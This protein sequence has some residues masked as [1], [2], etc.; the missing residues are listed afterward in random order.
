ML[1]GY[2]EPMLHKNINIICKRLS[3]VSFVEVVTNGDTLSSM[4][5]KEL[6]Q[7]N[8]N[9][10]LISMYDGSH[11]I[12]K[13]NKMIEESR[14]P[15]DFVILRDR[16]YDEKKDYGL[17]L[18]NR[19]GTINIG[20]QEKLEN[21]KCFYIVSILID[22][23]GDVFLCPQDWQRRV[24]MGNMMQEHIFDIWSGKIME[25]YRKIL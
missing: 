23:N 11:Q 4:K 8:V 1:C 22:W 5:I 14:V 15:K 7:N 9:K 17:K 2:G 25:K 24:T 19:T 13:F 12:E 21:I 20:D 6:Y 18:T 16:W 10:L 3:E